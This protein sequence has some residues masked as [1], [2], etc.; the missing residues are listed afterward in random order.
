[1]NITGEC[2]SDSD[3]D[4][5]DG[6]TYDFCEYYK[7]RHESSANLQCTQA[8][9]CTNYPGADY[10]A[11]CEYGK[12]NY[13]PSSNVGCTSD[14]NC[15]QSEWCDNMDHQC[16]RDMGGNCQCTTSQ[17]CTS[18]PFGDDTMAFCACN[19]QY[20]NTSDR[21][22]LYDWSDYQSFGNKSGVRFGWNGNEGGD[23]AKPF[24]GNPGAE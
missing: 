12:C 3:C 7:C 13:V 10:T 14:A 2:S 5:Y 1:M 8:A 23:E 4:D 22:W 21:Q 15:G 16:H 6:N 19:C 11:F 17:N 20:Y 24:S 18:K 9:Q